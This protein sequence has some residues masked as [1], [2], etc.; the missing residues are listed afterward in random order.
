[1]EKNYAQGSCVSA[2]ELQEDYNTLPEE[3]KENLKDL[4]EL[5]K[6][7]ENFPFPYSG[8]EAEDYCIEFGSAFKPYLVNKRKINQWFKV[9]KGKLERWLNCPNCNIEGFQSELPPFNPQDDYCCCLECNPI[10]LAS[11][12]M[13][14]SL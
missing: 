5:L 14:G 6:A 4:E 9:N 10:N 7:V 13:G 12:D 2:E 3:D 8:Y 11:D 1:M